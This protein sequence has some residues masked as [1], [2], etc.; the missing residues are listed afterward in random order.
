M[1]PL[2]RVL[3]FSAVHSWLVSF[4][5][6][7]SLSLLI[8]PLPWVGHCFSPQFFPLLPLSLFSSRPPA[9]FAF[10]PSFYFANFFCTFWPVFPL[11]LAGFA[12]LSP[13]APLP[14]HLVSLPSCCT[15][16]SP[17]PFF[18][19]FPCLVRFTCFHSSL[20]A[21]CSLFPAAP[22]RVVTCPASSS[23]SPP[24]SFQGTG[25][26]LLFHG[27]L[28]LPPPC[29]FSPPFHT[30]GDRA[31]GS[32]PT[33]CGFTTRLRRPRAFSSPPPALSPSPPVEL[34]SLASCLSWMPLLGRN[35]LDLLCSPPSTLCGSISRFRSR[36]PAP[37]PDSSLASGA[38]L[39]AC[40]ALSLRGGG[41][42]ADPLRL[43]LPSVSLP[44]FAAP[45]PF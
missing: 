27:R 9:F 1:A 37:A 19:T 38:S 7:L 22:A 16:P 32:A 40:C 11:L 34:P 43:I 39:E 3:W 33:A 29:E 31:P 12:P 2:L 20:S 35:V 30:C 26:C 14:R 15:P 25:S 21:S 36:A 5:A 44:P 41:T 24:P 23:A 17:F 45:S 8:F 6:P 4:V 10:G 13:Y 42:L 18:T 28:V